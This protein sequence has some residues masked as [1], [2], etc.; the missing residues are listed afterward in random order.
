MT[1]PELPK[2]SGWSQER[3]LGVQ[4]GHLLYC[5]WI[6]APV[7]CTFSRKRDS[8]VNGESWGQCYRTSESWDPWGGQPCPRRPTFLKTR[9]WVIYFCI[10]VVPGRPCAVRRRPSI[11]IC[12]MSVWMSKWQDAW[13]CLII[14]ASSSFPIFPSNKN[15]FGKEQGHEELNLLWVTREPRLSSRERSL[16]STGWDGKTEGVERVPETHSYFA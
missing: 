6:R 15:I 2:E 4:G 10:T 16:R 8:L 14:W 11:T 12:W 5:Q 1:C 13:I 3:N 9:A 7:F